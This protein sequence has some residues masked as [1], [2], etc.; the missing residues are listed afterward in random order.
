[1]N[2]KS[3][4][5]IS[6][7][8]GNL[9]KLPSVPT[10]V[11]E[12]L[13]S[14]DDERIEVNK[15]ANKIANDQALVARVMR[16]AN[17]AFFGLSGQVG[18]IS[19]AISVLG[20]NNLRGLVTAAS[21]IS[22]SPKNLGKFD[23]LDFWH[24]SLCTGAC[25]KVLAKQSGLNPEVAFTTGLLHDIGKLVIAMQFPEKFE[26]LSLHGESSEKSTNIE[27]ELIGFDHAFLG[28]QLAIRWKFPPAICKAIG[29]HHLPVEP[30]E[31]SR[32]SDIVYL[33]NVFAHV[34]NNKD[35]SNSHPSRLA[36]D[37]WDRLQ[38]RADLLPILTAEA[39]RLYSGSL[40]LLSA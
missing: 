7:I 11:L 2:N 8:L 32:L 14:F 6:E 30:T 1:M 39:E 37:A 16:V 25:S 4:H 9:Q 13:D 35:D 36:E 24:H 10:L 21:I 38:I 12:I 40:L 23:I 19:D 31:Q 33:A 18:T 15:L 26:Q 34:L 20:F 28:E 3:T 17:S 5:T 27:R 29:Q 22:A